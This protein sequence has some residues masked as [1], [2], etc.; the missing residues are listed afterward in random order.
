[1]INSKGEAIL[2]DFG[3]CSILKDGNDTLIKD[4]KGSYRYFAPELV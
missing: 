4:N 1:M 2:C 3:V